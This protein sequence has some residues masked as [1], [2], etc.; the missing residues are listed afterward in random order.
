[1]FSEAFDL[2]S[3]YKGGN[4]V[5]NKRWGGYCDEGINYG[6]CC[7][8]HALFTDCPDPHAWLHGTGLVTHRGGGGFGWGKFRHPQIWVPCVQLREISWQTQNWGNTACQISR[9]G[10][11][12]VG[13]PY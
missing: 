1:M 12:P 5:S 6:C 4:T 13:S 3:C 9:K 7:V 11:G 2:M 10:Q 8:S